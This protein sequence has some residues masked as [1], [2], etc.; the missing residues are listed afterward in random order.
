VLLI[1]NKPL[2]TVT[3]KNIISISNTPFFSVKGRRFVVLLTV[4]LADK[5]LIS[6]PQAAALKCTLRAFE[7]RVQRRMFGPERDYGTG[8][9]RR[10]HNE[11][12]Y[13]LY[14]SPNITRV[15]KSRERWAANVAGVGDMRSEY[16]F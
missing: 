11:E 3:K 4:F 6:V 16:I 14:S 2:K 15:I 7:S 10:L 9:W 1:L 8:E 5:T 13:A 12:L